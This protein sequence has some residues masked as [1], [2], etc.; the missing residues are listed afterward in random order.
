[1]GVWFL[2]NAAGYALCGTLGSLL[3]ATGPKYIEA[4]EKLGIDLKGVLDQTITAT[5]EQLAKLKELN[6]PTTYT[7]F[8]GFTIHNLYEFVMMF[9]ILPLVAGILLFVLTP[10]LKKMMHGVR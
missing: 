3:P 7:H 5:P 2:A 10:K 6:I 9:V 4:Q 1:M 8:A